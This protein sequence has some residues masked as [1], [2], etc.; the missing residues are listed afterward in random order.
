MGACVLL[1]ML[2]PHYEW[3]GRLSY[4]IAIGVV[5]LLI[6]VLFA[7][8]NRGVHRWFALPANL[9]LQPSELAKIAFVLSLAWYLRWQR[10]HREL[11]GLIG[12]FLLM[13]VPVALIL[14]EPDLGTALL[15]P[16]VGY[17]MLIAA[18]RVCGTS[19]RS[20]SS[21]WF[22][23]RGFTRFSVITSRTESRA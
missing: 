4:P 7:D 20:R 9:Q 22:A 13:L 5:I 14:I 6:A 11:T 16:L 23:C 10:D 19:W 12:P 2:I 17:A 8:P 21:W 1:L 15:F 18:G 3:F